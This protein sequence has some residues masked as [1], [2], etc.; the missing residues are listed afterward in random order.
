MTISLPETT[1]AGARDAKGK[2]PKG[3][4]NRMVE[5]RLIAISKKRQAYERAGR[6]KSKTN[7]DGSAESTQPG[8]I[9]PGDDRPRGT[10]RRA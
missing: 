3:A 10:G 8:K 6:P 2:Y 9:K 7:D 4:I 1:P 5:D